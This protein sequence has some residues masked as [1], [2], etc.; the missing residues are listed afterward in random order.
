MKSALLTPFD[1]IKAAYAIMGNPRLLA[2]CLAP[3]LIGVVSF[4]V[5]ISLM[6]IY[7][8][9]LTSLIITDAN[10]WW[11][12]IVSWFLMLLGVFVSGILALIVLSIIGAIFIEL[13]IE[14]LLV[15][16]GLL[17]E[18][19]FSLKRI[20]RSTVFAIKDTLERLLIIGFVSL[21]L[22]VFSF[23]PVLYLVSLFLGVFLIGFNLVEQPLTL[24]QYNI[25]HRIKLARSNWREVLGLGITFSIV[26]LIPL[27]AVLLLPLAYYVAV[28]RIATW[29]F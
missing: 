27:G 26:M 10:G 29:R 22:I 14:S 9:D 13:F 7:R 5:F 15:S 23:F 12:L 19:P 17:D 18:Q 21:T 16:R 8:G 11:Y 2:L 3:M 1:F 20:V 28:E 6:F 25:R 24:L 4:V